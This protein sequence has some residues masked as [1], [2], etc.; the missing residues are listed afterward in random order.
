MRLKVLLGLIISFVIVGVAGLARA[1]VI[2]NFV[3]KINPFEKL[4]LA[5][6]L[7]NETAFGIAKENDGWQKFKNVFDLKG[8]YKL[9][10]SVE[11]Y[12]DINYWYDSV[13]EIDDRYDSISKKDKSVLRRP[14]DKY[15]L[16]EFYVDVLTDAVDLR[17]G[18]QYVVWGTTDGVRILDL[19]NPLDLREWTL[20]EFSDLRIP[21]WMLK[22]ESSITKNG[23]LQLL[24]IPDYE[25]N[26]YP[27]AGAPFALRSTVI[28]AES[29]A[30]PFVSVRTIDNKPE[31]TLEDSKIGLR[32][33]DVVE[34]GMFSGLEYT[35]N[36]LHTYDSAATYY[37]STAPGFPVPIKLT[38]NAEQ[39]E[40][41]G[42]SFAKSITKGLVGDFGKGWTLRGEFAYIANGAMNYGTDRN[43]VST[44]DVDQYNYALG[45][46]K[47]CLTNWQFSTQFIQMI[48]KSKEDFDDNKYTLLFGPTRGPLDEIENMITLKVSTDFIHERLKPECLILY[49]DDNDWRLAP[50]ISF[51]V[52]DN[53]I[54]AAGLNFFFGK[55]TQMN[56]QFDDS[57]QVFL[58]TKYSW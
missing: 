24:V 33:R 57:D 31:R 32:W 55:E 23:G 58:E 43:I 30:S 16:K 51:E 46:D 38:R 7:K 15:I 44:V 5:G 17:A 11:F 12:T 21:L 10:D 41:W 39:I 26:Y 3:D 4:E 54:V 36:Y 8:N 56:G 18:K 53:L 14:E 50:K 35:L 20:K 6:Y 9:N 25:P 19:V 27:P 40:V 47:T 49:G 48:A 34:T 52:N 37:V 1:E 22:A 2:G 29:A 42:G 28:G 13:L 45:F